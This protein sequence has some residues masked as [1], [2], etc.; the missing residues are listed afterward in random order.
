MAGTDNVLPNVAALSFHDFS[1]VDN[2]PPQ[3]HLL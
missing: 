3:Q 1:P 2:I